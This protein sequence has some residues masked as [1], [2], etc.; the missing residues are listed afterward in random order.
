MTAPRAADLPV[1]SRV[2][3]DSGDLIAVR[4]T[5]AIDGWRVNGL[6]AF[7]DHEIDEWLTTGGHAEVLRVGDGGGR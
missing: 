4:F 7:W 1:G 2:R 5:H 3:N 6:G